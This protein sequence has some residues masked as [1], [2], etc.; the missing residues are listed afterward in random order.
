MQRPTVRGV[1]FTAAALLLCGISALAATGLAYVLRP[2]PPP[3]APAE[4]QLPAGYFRDWPKPDLALVLSGEQHGYLLPCGCSRP[5]YGGLERRYNLMALLRRRG[6][7]VTALDVGDVPQAEGPRKLPNVQGLLKY[8]YAMESMKEMGY[9]AVG[10]GDYEAGLPLSNALAEYALNND[11]P[12]VLAANIKAAEKNFPD[13][14]FPTRVTKVEGSPLTVGVAAVVGPSVQGKIKLRDANVKFDDNRLVIPRL[15]T[16]LGRTADLRVLIY[17]GS[18]EEAQALAG[19]RKDFH[20]ILCLSP[21]DEPR[22]DP[23]WVGGT[24]VATV[25]HKGRYV[26]VVGVSRTGKADRPFE[27]R[28]QLVTLGEEFLTASGKE[29]GHPI[30]A[31]MEQ[32]TRELQRDD[33]LARYG[34]SKHPNQVAVPG[35]VPTY[36][37]SQKCKKC[38]GPAY[39]VW[40]KSKHAHAYEALVKATRPSL[41]Q[42]DGECIVCHTV[43]FAYDS[44]FKNERATPHL[45]HVG[46]E[47]C[48]GPA[49]EHVKNPKDAKWRQLL[50][51]WKGKENETEEQR[52]Q[53]MLRVNDLCVQCHDVDNDVKFKFEKRWPEIEH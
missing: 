20:I 16:E 11:S 41:R 46:C 1:K 14:V 18:L 23:V 38:H 5:Q 3:P 51:P 7:P 15:A 28:Y 19:D 40:E 43:G 45:K 37:G 10:L 34:Q 8:R 17:H 9:L 48:H 44:G 30:L 53:H 4:P 2:T 42:Y 6:W 50:N 49:S 25:G 21:E 47:S 29:K 24:L 12:R 39:D 35:V 26:G 22:S 13:Q 33:Y 36:V 52:R 27:L 31:K 32:Y